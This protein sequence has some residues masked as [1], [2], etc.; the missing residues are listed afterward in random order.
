[1][2]PKKG[3]NQKAYDKNYD[4]IDW[5]STRKSYEDNKPTKQKSK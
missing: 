5:S 2:Q 3:Y 4:D 1:M